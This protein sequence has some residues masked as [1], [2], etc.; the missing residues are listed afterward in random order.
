MAKS[1]D[2][3]VSHRMAVPHSP[4][5]LVE[6]FACGGN[7]QQQKK[8]GKTPR[9]RTHGWPKVFASPGVFSPGATDAV[10]HSRN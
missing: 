9:E 5:E 3:I 7:V 2:E 6:C 1:K 4:R 8:C 10:D